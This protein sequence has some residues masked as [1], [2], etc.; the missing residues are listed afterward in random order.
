MKD[1]MYWISRRYNMAESRSYI[2]QKEK[3]TEICVTEQR[4][5]AAL[6]HSQ[7]FLS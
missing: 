4:A 7:A 3:R 1:A 6:S 5:A 2:N